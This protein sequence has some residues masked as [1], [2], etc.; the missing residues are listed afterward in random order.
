MPLRPHFLCCL[1]AAILTPSVKG[2]T[3][4]ITDAQ[5]S[6][7]QNT[8]V[9][10]SLA[11]LVADVRVREGD[12]VEPGDRLI[13]LDTEQALTELEAAKAAYE[14]ARLSSDQDVH[15][16]YA[17]RTKE[18]RQRELEQ[19]LEA[20]QRYPGTVSETEI[21]KQ[22]LEV[23]QAQL[24]IEQAQHEKLVANARV[25]EKQAAIVSAEAKLRRHGIVTPVR[26]EVVE[27]AVDAGEWVDTGKP[28]V[29]II[30]LDPIRV[31]CFLEEASRGNDLEGCKVKFFP[32]HQDAA[33]STAAE[34][35]LMGHVTF[36]SSELHP[37]TGQARL[38][39]EIA[40]PDQ[41][42][43]A[44]THGRLVIELRP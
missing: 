32:E 2:Q 17:Q 14:V 1:F 9:A 6:L 20:N 12:R 3:V 24:G 43:R 42:V 35:P 21:S 18:V 25:R 33:S 22:Q 30:S 23:D 36:V 31:E 41:R 28:V 40:N 11:G 39:A 5:V 26:G 4:E 13:Q 38:W 37:V 15:V 27:V 7:I 10:T 16:R 29:R 34:S 8:F 44:G 19:S